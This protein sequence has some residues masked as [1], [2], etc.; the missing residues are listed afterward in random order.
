MLGTD[1]R[2]GSPCWID[3][4]SPDVEAAAAYYGA[5]FGWTFQSLGPEAMGYGFLQ[6]DGR[7]VGAIGPLTEDGATSA[8]TIYFQ[9]PDADAT[10][11]DVQ[12][13][14]GTVRVEPFDVM[15]A[16][17]MACLTDPAGAEF[18]TWQA[19][20]TQ[21]V[22]VT[23][24][25]NTLLWAELHTP[26]PAA[27]LAFYGAV[28]GWRSQAMEAPGMTYH[29]LSTAEGDLEDTS[30]GGVAPDDAAGHPY[31]VP[32]FFATD[33][34]D[35]CARSTANGG[36]VVMPADDVP[37]VGRIA[38]LADPAGAVF[39]VLKPNPRQG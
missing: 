26:D 23:N 5:V 9:T 12:S 22:E 8:W 18:A 11:K 33:P 6:Q 35:I 37:E 30:F 36:S 17:R 14:G 31:W 2:K 25:P 16:G 3:L 13:H 39:A 27:A 15:T 1:F 32:Y 29:V 34:D 7:T 10:A 24:E 4:G 28:Y 21:G 20:E 19:G 38:F